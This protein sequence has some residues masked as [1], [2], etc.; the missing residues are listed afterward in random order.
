[1]RKRGCNFREIRVAVKKTFSTASAS[2]NQ[3]IK[4]R[5]AELFFQIQK[6]IL[7]IKIAKSRLKMEEVA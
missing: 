2:P 7:A 6:Q 3:C 1:M 5:G 4:E